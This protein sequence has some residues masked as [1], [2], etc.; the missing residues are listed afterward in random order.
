MG[1]ELKRALN[2]IM[3]FKSEIA[4]PPPDRL[5]IAV[6][7]LREIATL[8]ADTDGQFDLDAWGL[9]INRVA[10]KALTEI[11]AELEAERVASVNTARVN[12]YADGRDAERADVVAWL[13]GDRPSDYTDPQY[14]IGV[15]LARGIEANA[16]RSNPDA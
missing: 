11:G 16:H 6:A 7:A 3:A 13:R 12:A 10:E 4:P 1:D 2:A 5:A 15:N 14:D 8:A 9:L